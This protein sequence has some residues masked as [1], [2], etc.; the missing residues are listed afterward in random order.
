MH[1]REVAQAAELARA[2]GDQLNKM[3]RE[4]VRLERLDVTGTNGQPSAIRCAAAALRLDISEAQFLID[5]LRLRYLNG[6]GHAPARQL[7]QQ[8]R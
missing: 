7:A 6:N 1:A 3:T 2:L 5:R 8:A 4:L